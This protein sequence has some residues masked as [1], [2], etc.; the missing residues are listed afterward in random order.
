[1]PS[2]SIR[3]ASLDALYPSTRPKMPDVNLLTSFSS[4]SAVQVDRSETPYVDMGLRVGRELCTAAAE[5]SAPAPPSPEEEVLAADER[6]TILRTS[7]AL[8]ARAL[9]LRHRRESG[10]VSSVSS[11]GWVTGLRRDLGLVERDEEID[12]GAVD[13]ES[14][15]G[16]E[17]EDS[18]EGSNKD[19]STSYCCSFPLP[20]L[21]RLPFPGPRLGTEVETGERV[22]ERA[23][24]VEGTAGDGTKDG[25]GM[26]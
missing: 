26:E 6:E 12:V 16:L 9:S 10:L 21:R 1:M 7:W 11:E 2:D 13:E 15:E 8:F 24:V 17:T 14:R 23:S 5:L 22:V 25:D 19:C 18:R 3:G 4:C 20:F